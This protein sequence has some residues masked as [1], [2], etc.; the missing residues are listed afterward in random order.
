MR[1]MLRDVCGDS[2]EEIWLDDAGAL[3][4]AEGLLHHLNPHHSLRLEL[5]SGPEPLFTRFGIAQPILCL[6]QREVDLPDGAKIVIDKTQGLTAID[7]LP[8]RLHVGKGWEEQ[9][10]ATNLEAASEIARQLKLRNVSGLAVIDFLDMRGQRERRKVEQ[11]LTDATRRDIGMVKL[12]PMS[13]F[14]LIELARRGVRTS[15]TEFDEEIG[16]DAPIFICYRREETEHQV[17]RIGSLGISVRATSFTTRI[18][19]RLASTGCNTLI[20]PSVS[21]PCCLL[22]SAIAGWRS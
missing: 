6:S 21:V 11:V 10:L 3:S 14:G 15:S 8:G 19:S 13:A 2:V 5:H 9:V 12:L 1:R 7:V 4:H 16:S 18:R 17:G 22:R 20:R